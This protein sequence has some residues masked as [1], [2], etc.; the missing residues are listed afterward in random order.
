MQAACRCVH[1][2]HMHFA[3]HLAALTVLPHRLALGW[4][5]QSAATQAATDLKRTS[6]TAL[7]FRNTM[8]GPRLSRML[9]FDRPDARGGGKGKDGA[10]PARRLSRSLSLRLSPETL[11]LRGLGQRRTLQAPPRR[12]A[13]AAHD[14]PAR[15]QGPSAG[16]GSFFRRGSSAWSKH[17]S[18]PEL[19]D[20]APAPADGAEPTAAAAAA[21][22]DASEPRAQQERAMQH[23]SSGLSM[24]SRLTDTP[25][26]IDDS[27]SPGNSFKGSFKTNSF[28]ALGSFKLDEQP[29]VSSNPG[30]TAAGAVP[31]DARPK[32]PPPSSGAHAAAAGGLGSA[33]A[34]NALAQRRQRW[35]GSRLRQFSRLLTRSTSARSSASDTSGISRTSS[36][37]AFFNLQSSLSMRW[38][39]AVNLV[40]Q[41]GKAD[42]GSA[43]ADSSAA[44][45]Q[46]EIA[47]QL[48]LLLMAFKYLA[49]LAQVRVGVEMACMLACTHFACAHSQAPQRPSSAAT[50]SCLLLLPVRTFRCCARWCWT[51]HRLRPWCLGRTC[52]C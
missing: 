39:T 18:S 5:S 31:R 46:A 19:A 34:A 49:C 32:T 10:A 27:S 4:L 21:G 22:A 28:G 36:S 3:T 29:S 38:S 52:C 2:T 30:T 12:Q 23:N 51:A 25:S 11:G 13:Q 9:S 7:T 50:H 37:S 17:G 14:E 44:D 47:Q 1:G 16:L 48:A 35:G 45:R 41:A 24:S 20:T 8:L 6:S 43:A 40:D 42:S 26:W 33:G 15:R